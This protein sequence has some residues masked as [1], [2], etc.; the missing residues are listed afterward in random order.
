M[1]NLTLKFGSLKAWDFTGNER[2]IALL[3]EYE[4]AGAAA[5]A[6]QQHDTARQKE[7]I[8][9]L[10]DECDD[11]EG[12]YLDWDGRY[13]TKDDAKAYI[14]NYGKPRAPLVDA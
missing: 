4:S 8:C 12:I 10:I 3:H 14:A 7:I 6:M 9:T 2:A 5:G 11:P 13:V 1:S